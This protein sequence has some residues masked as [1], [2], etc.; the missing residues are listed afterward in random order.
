VVP[1][2]FS[3]LLIPIRTLRIKLLSMANYVL[4][5]KKKKSKKRK[6]KCTLRPI[7]KIAIKKA[8]RNSCFGSCSFFPIIKL[9][10]IISYDIKPYIAY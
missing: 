2:S 8:K 7:E 10:P 3:D 1:R 9:N 6:Q 5:I 4:W